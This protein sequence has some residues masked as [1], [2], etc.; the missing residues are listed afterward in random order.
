MIRRKR[1]RS[2]TVEAYSGFFDPSP[3]LSE[4]VKGFIDTQHA[5]CPSRSPS[6]PP[7]A[8]LVGPAANL[9]PQDDS[10]NGSIDELADPENPG[11]LTVEAFL[12]R[13]TGRPRST[14]KRRVLR[15]ES[16]EDYR[17][18]EDSAGSPSA[19]RRLLPLHHDSPDQPAGP[20]PTKKKKTA[21]FSRRLVQAA[22]N[23][24]GIIPAH[25]ATPPRPA[26]TFVLANKNP[27]LKSNKH[28]RKRGHLVDPRRCSSFAG[29]LSHF[30]P[31]KPEAGLPAAGAAAVPG[32]A[33]VRVDLALSNNPALL[34][35]KLTKPHAKWTARAPPILPKAYL[36]RPPDP[37]P[38]K[39]THRRSK[40]VTDAAAPLKLVP[41]AESIV[42]VCGR[43]GRGTAGR[44][45]RS[46]MKRG[47][48][49]L[50]CDGPGPLTFVAVATRKQA[51]D[52]DKQNQT[53]GT[54]S[55][56]AMNVS[57][58][59]MNVSSPTPVFCMTSV[60]NRLSGTGGSAGKAPLTAVESPLVES[61]HCTD[62]GDIIDLTDIVDDNDL[63]VPN[64]DLHA[65][66]DDLNAP[67]HGL[68]APIND[69]N[70]PIDDLTGPIEDVIAPIE[71]RLHPCDDSCHTTSQTRSFASHKQ[72]STS[73][74]KRPPTSSQKQSSTSLHKQSSSHKPLKPLAAFHD[75]LAE[76]VRTATQLVDAALRTPGAR[77]SSR[78]RTSE[79]KTH[80][81]GTKTLPSEKKSRSST[82]RSVRPRMSVQPSITSMLV[83]RAPPSA[84]SPRMSSTR[85]PHTPSTRAL[86]NS[87]APSCG[88]PATGS[89]LPAPVTSPAPLA[90]PAPQTLASLMPCAL[91]SSPPLLCLPS[92]SSPSMAVRLRI[93]D[94]RVHISSR[95]PVRTPT[96][97]PLAVSS[98]SHL[99]DVSDPS[100]DIRSCSPP[101]A[102]AFVMHSVRSLQAGRTR[103][104]PSGDDLQVVWT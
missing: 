54:T 53:P 94:D 96:G 59:A 2:I 66:I 33:A 63:T 58:P 69:L 81:T 52:V 4:R 36:A 19:L 92:S 20:P 64:D 39:K 24:G 104:K 10:F 43:A 50:A 17:P 1:K 8:C 67:I 37:D 6:C 41:L 48:Q 11:P 47:K 101:P 88:S 95:I 86:R 32:G 13:S 79:D 14:R 98:G 40:K 57:S 99:E 31:P 70:V 34:P 89:A 84:R 103:S 83:S 60:R 27:P 42:H 62:A 97:I 29:S 28:P 30:Y 90:L 102:S 12:K 77:G 38:R 25:P 72:F 65:S 22:L 78:T 71:A 73:S 5:E 45:G 100:S 68:T 80:S 21:R 9:E 75:R 35:P 56:P 85:P 44:T 15:V 51:K 3:S 16:D 46:V 61:A 26:L 55:L 49:V 82:S 23:T 93:S 76:T 87:T 74:K 91:S 18:D 7:I